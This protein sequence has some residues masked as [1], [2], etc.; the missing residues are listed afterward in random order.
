MPEQ[1][2]IGREVLIKDGDDFS[3]RPQA[4]GDASLAPKRNSNPKTH[5]KTAQRQ[6]PGPTLLLGNL[7]FETTEADILE[8]LLVEAAVMAILR[9]GVGVKVAMAVPR[10]AEGPEPRA[11]R[12]R[13]LLVAPILGFGATLSAIQSYPH[14]SVP[15]LAQILAHLS[16]GLDSHSSILGVLKKPRPH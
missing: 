16:S 13:R 2:L 12:K 1:P 9:M 14:P 5:S 6:P 7:G 3:G 11:R 4:A 8:M 15:S 10:L